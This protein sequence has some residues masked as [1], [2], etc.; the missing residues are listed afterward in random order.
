MVSCENPRGSY[1]WQIA[2]FD[3]LCT[4]TRICVSGFQNCMHGG[5]RDKWSRF[6]SNNHGFSRLAL[7]CDG[8]HEHKPW[9]FVDPAL[10]SSDTPW[11]FA[12]SQ[13]AQYPKLLCERIADLVCE[14]A[15]ARG[16]KFT[17]KGLASLE[18]MPHDAKRMRVAANRQPRGQII[19][20]LISEFKAVEVVRADELHEMHRLL[21]PV[22]QGKSAGAMSSYTVSPQVPMV[23]AGVFRSPEEFIREALQVQHPFD[24][25]VDLPEVSSKALHNILRLGPV[26]LS[27]KRCSAI[28]AVC[29]RAKALQSREDELHQKMELGI[30]QSDLA[31][32]NL[33]TPWSAL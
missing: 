25:H 33:H 17:P 29:L 24:M 3:R 22:L 31:Y 14:V 7:E 9:G 4:D 6:I 10:S 21:R 1:L 8:G 16:V 15:T 5:E 26:G 23:M 19:L 32:L 13:E 27:A 12:T 30:Q 20:P 28:R 18:A 11:V 2:P